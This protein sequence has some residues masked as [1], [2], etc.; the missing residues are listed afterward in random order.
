MK[1]CSY[2]QEKNRVL[3]WRGGYCT[4]YRVYI[5]E[6]LAFFHLLV[7]SLIFKGHFDVTLYR[8]RNFSTF[9]V[10]FGTDLLGK[11]EKRREICW[12]KMAKIVTHMGKQVIV[13][14]DRP[15]VWR[16][17]EEAAKGLGVS[18]STIS[19]AIREARPDYRYVSRVFAIKLRGG[20]WKIAVADSSN[21]RYITVEQDLLKIPKKDV[22][23]VKDIT[24]VWY[25]SREEW[26]SGTE[27][28]GGFLI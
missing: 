27:F 14:K 22:E 2:I 8:I 11:V 17:L 19:R 21:R 24:A 16:T 15:G 9:R 10:L 23:K 1:K 18:V 7:K 25:F 20:P 5:G 26:N 4:N 13:C 12:R 28:A 6:F 3:I